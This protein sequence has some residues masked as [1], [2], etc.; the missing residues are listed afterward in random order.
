MSDVRRS[1][2]SKGK[3]ALVLGLLSATFAC[4][5]TRRTNRSCS[6]GSTASGSNP[7]VLRRRRANA[8]F[9]EATVEDFERY[10]WPA[11]GP[12]RW[13][14]FSTRSEFLQNGQV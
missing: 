11:G 12:A 10:L 13:C 6:R 9:A 1:V 14:G 7:P 8:C 5:H 2:S 4:P 3:S